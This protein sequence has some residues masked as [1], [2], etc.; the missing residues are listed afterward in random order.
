MIVQVNSNLQ[1]HHQGYRY[2]IRLQGD[3][4]K[5]VLYCVYAALQNLSEVHLDTEGHILF[6]NLFILFNNMIRT[7][8]VTL[9]LGTV[10][11]VPRENSKR[12]LTDQNKTKFKSFLILKAQNNNNHKT[13]LTVTPGGIKAWRGQMYFSQCCSM[14]RIYFSVV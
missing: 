14:G 10:Q 4:L 11:K 2:L 12:T 5:V 9:T 7:P 6:C 13:C 1:Q 8:N 3:G